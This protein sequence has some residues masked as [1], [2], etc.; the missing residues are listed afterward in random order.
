[1]FCSTTENR[2]QRTTGRKWHC[3]IYLPPF[4]QKYVTIRNI[5]ATNNR[6]TNEAKKKVRTERKISKFIATLENTNT[7]L[8]N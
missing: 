4:H 1:M 8:I 6:T 7:I 2:N 3:N 5:Y